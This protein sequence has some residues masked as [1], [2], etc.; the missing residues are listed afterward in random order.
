MEFNF[1]YRSRRGYKP[2]NPPPNFSFPSSHTITSIKEKMFN[3]KDITQQ[4]GWVCVMEDGT[5]I[6]VESFSEAHK[7]PNKKALMSTE[8]YPQYSQLSPPKKR[9]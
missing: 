9:S 6:E 8:F 4:K 7:I 1:P 3:R 2:L 5:T